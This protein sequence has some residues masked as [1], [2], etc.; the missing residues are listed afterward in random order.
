MANKKE[1]KE[2]VV[3]EAQEVK[4]EQE[5]RKQFSLSFTLK[6]L[7]WIFA[8]VSLG[9]SLIWGIIVQFGVFIGVGTGVFFLLAIGLAITGLVLS[10]IDSKGKFNLGL[11][12]NAFAIL[13]TVVM[14]F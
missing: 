1:E 4:Q 5:P 14:Y 12:F 10:I 13:I 9:I 6:T 3:A 2:V 7:A 8:I 11:G